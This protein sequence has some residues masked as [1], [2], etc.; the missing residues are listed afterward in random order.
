MREK[1]LICNHAKVYLEKLLVISKAN[2]CTF[3]SCI[4]ISSIIHHDFNKIYA[5]A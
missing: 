1:S 4:E 2:A 3:F 5:N